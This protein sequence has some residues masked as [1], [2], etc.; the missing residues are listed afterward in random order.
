MFL[1]VT[2]NAAFAEARLELLMTITPY[3]LTCGCF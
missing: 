2:Y 3:R 1:L